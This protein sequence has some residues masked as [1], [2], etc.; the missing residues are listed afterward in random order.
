MEFLAEYYTY[1]NG[2]EN[3]DRYRYI[4]VLQNSNDPEIKEAFLKLANSCDKYI[5]NSRS[6]SI[7]AKQGETFEAFKNRF[8]DKV[9]YFI[10]DKKSEPAYS[11]INNMIYDRNDKFSTFFNR[12]GQEIIKEYL[13]YITNE[14]NNSE[15]SKFFA[16]L[17]KSNDSDWL[18]IKNYMDKYLKDLGYNK[19]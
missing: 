9:K 14:D 11:S 13:V 4:K 18:A 10:F 3:D 16:Q 5:S 17:D 19:S 6:A 2:Y 15:S 8:N 12:S 1:K 7:Q